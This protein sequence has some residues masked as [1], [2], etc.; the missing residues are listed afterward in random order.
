MTYNKTAAYD[1]SLFDTSEKIEKKQDKKPKNKSKVVHMPE[2]AI[3]K[4]RYRK[5]NPLKVFFGTLGLCAATAV[6]AAIIVGQVQL[7]ELNQKIITAEN[8]LS[9]EKSVYTQTQMAVQSNLST[10]GIQQYAEEQLGMTKAENSQKEFIELSQGDKA[11]VTA[12]SNG[13]FFSWIAKA[14][15]GL[16]S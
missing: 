8:T 3:N 16:W 15:S 2:E 1:L 14:V 11:E 12:D 13:D 6:I 5:H 7:T 10:S 4:I 9:N